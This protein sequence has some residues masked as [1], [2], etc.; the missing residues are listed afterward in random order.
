MRH[1]RPL[2]HPFEGDENWPKP[3]ERKPAAPEAKPINV[4]SSEGE[5][6]PRLAEQVLNK[7]EAASATGSSK[8]RT[9]QQNLGGKRHE[10]S[11]QRTPNVTGS[12]AIHVKSF[13]CKLTGDSLTFLDQQINE[14]LDSHPQYEVK[15]VTTTVGEWSGKSKEPNIIINIWV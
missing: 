10:N 8:I 7:T 14:W 1:A 12:G 3:V 4:S 15:L 9:F 6:D 13:H 11:W 2:L 5:V